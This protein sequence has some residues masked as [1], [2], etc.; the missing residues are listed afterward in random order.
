MPP[1]LYNTGFILMEIYK[2]C[3]VPCVRI[4]VRYGVDEASCRKTSEN[5]QRSDRFPFVFIW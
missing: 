3:W 5:E 2:V 1:F 4:C